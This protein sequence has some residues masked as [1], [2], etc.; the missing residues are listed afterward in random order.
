MYEDTDCKVS[1]YTVMGAKDYQN[2]P[3]SCERHSEAISGTEELK[4]REIRESFCSESELRNGN[5]QDR[6]THSHTVRDTAVKFNSVLPLKIN[7]PP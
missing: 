1:V 7:S 6:M 3:F 5:T 4:A 2:L